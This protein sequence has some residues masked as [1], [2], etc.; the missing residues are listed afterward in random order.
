MDDKIETLEQMLKESTEA[1]NEA[2]RKYEEVS[3]ADT[4]QLLFTLVS[5]ILDTRRDS[6]LGIRGTQTF[7]EF[8]DSGNLG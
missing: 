8:S 7:A 2:E 6:Q 5:E 4:R 1:A 3:I